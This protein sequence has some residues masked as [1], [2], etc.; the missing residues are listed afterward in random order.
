[1]R[2]RLIL[3][4]ILCW[5]GTGGF[6]QEK[7]V[8]RRADAFFVEWMPGNIR[9]SDDQK[10]VPLR[11]DT[12]YSI[13][14]E[15]SSPVK[16]IAAWKDGR[17]YSIKAIKINDKRMEVGVQKSTNKKIIVTAGAANKLWMLQLNRQGSG[18]P[19]A[20]LAKGQIL[21]QGK[22]GQSTFIYRIKQQVELETVP[23][24]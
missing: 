19:P 23:S 2:L 22:S 18:G 12:L 21:L 14:V 11:P 10:E 9:S 24:V 17:K 20:K 3:S 1:M 15:L 5:F 8:V 6:T 13:Y 4:V 16:W 7:K